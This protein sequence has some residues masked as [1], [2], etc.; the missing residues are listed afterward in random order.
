MSASTATLRR[1]VFPRVNVAT[2]ALLVLGGALFVALTAQISIPLPFTP[3]PLTGQTFGVLLVAASLGSVLGSLSM[4]TYLFLGLVG[5]PVYADQSSGWDIVRGATGGYLLGFIVAALVIGF[6][7]ER[8][9]DQNFSSSVSAMLTGN[10]IIFAVGLSWLAWWLGDNGLPNG[11]SDVLEAGLYPFV[12][13]EVLKLYLAGAL[14][15]LAWK[16]VERFK[17]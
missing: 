13:G 16:A 6:L 1:A 4:L 8:R 2:S 5:L 14:L 17:G 15:P 11:L 7:A 3:V 10:V 9:W 12:P